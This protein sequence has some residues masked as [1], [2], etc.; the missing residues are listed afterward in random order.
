MTGERLL[1]TGIGAVTWNGL[2]VEA[3]GRALNGGAATF[4]SEETSEGQSV[5]IGRV[6]RLRDTDAASFYPRWGQLDTYSRYG[7]SAARMALEESG[8]LAQEGGRDRIGVLLGTAFG[9]IEENQ[10]FDRYEVEDGVVRGASPLVFKGTVDNAPAGWIAVAWKLQGPNA[11]FVSGDG[12]ALE[13]LWSA[14]GLLRANRAEALVVGGVERFVDLHLRLRRR[15]ASRQGETLSEGSGVAIVEREDAFLR[16]GGDLAEV[17]AEL[18]GVARTTGQ[19]GD[20]LP[21]ALKGLGV[22]LG[23]VG[24]VSVAS[25]SEDELLS[26]LGNALPERV[27]LVADKVRLGEFHG[28]WGGVALCAAL[29]RLGASGAGWNGRPHAVVHAFGEGREN[30]FAVLREV[31]G[32]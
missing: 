30:F 16:R 2:G 15:D 9:C 12:A 10:R 28:A 5:P 1:V 23:D 21:S 32:R 8:I 20:A 6:G 22:S 7:F 19:L 14:E 25:P 24:L 29:Y 3:V 31:S 13:A 18:V 17:R 11:T 4:P 27:E 26:E